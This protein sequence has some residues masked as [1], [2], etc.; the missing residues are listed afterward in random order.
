MK[1]RVGNARLFVALGIILCAL[2]VLSWRLFSISW[3]KHSAYAQ[4]AQAQASGISSVL[5]RGSIYLTDSSG[6]EQ[7]VAT[8]RKFPALVITAGKI[9]RSRLDDLV[10]RLVEITGLSR[11]AV[12]KS[13][14]ADMSGSRPLL[15]KL[16]DEQVAAV[17]DL[18]ASGVSVGY[19]VD[20]SYPAG[21][22]A[23]DVIG[24]LGY[25]QNGRA[26]QYGVES[27]YNRELTGSSET[28]SP[29]R[30]N[31]LGQ[32]RRLFGRTESPAL[33]ESDAPRDI[34]LTLDKNIQI[35][36]Q[37][38]LDSVLKKYNAA[39]GVLL[40]QEP[41]TGRMLA[42]ADSPS[43]DPNNYSSYP[44]VNF[45]NG[46][47]L[48][49]EPGSSFKPFTMA[50]AIDAGKVAPDTT[51]DDS[52]D[53]IVDG[54]TIKNFNEGHFGRVTMS[55]V[56][57]KSINTGVM[58]VQQKIGND[59]FLNGTI[60]MGF[61]QRTGI[62]VSSEASGDI[63]NLY[64]GRRINFMTASFGQGITVTPIQLINGYSAIANGGKLMRPYVVAALRNEHG[65]R[66]ATK[67]EIIGTPF[68]A[69][70]AAAIRGMLVSVVDNGFDKARIPRYDIAGKT[71]TAQ[72]ASPDGGYLEGQ[73]NHSFVGFAPASDPKF[74][75]F[76][77]ME[78]PQGITFAADSLSPAFKD[79]ASFLLNYFNV[80]PTR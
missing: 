23:S 30:W 10:G 16:S 53:V 44:I 39:S 45:L 12:A 61:G 29:V 77:R 31:I 59:V 1:H 62:D 74:V 35:Y 21:A 9:D 40:V 20:R 76:I 36:A 4:T 65:V 25:G 14:G 13:V 28:T 43:F 73:Y 2:G 80:P 6:A 46:A 49:F 32:L 15:R 7:L 56:L 72:I 51:F 67:P 42:M 48:P 41:N 79:M 34:E 55:K 64:S 3:Q 52:G 33:P 22:L 70:T 5:T 27:F 57:E 78:K 17:A 75:I 38:V 66:V 18:H 19:E 60:A 8:N 58:W 37:S 71:G 50:M 63:S 47:L 69:K 24:F 54:Y 11:E 26:G 68:S